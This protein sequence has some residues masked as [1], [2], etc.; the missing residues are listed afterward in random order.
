MVAVTLLTIIGTAALMVFNGSQ[1][2][3]TL[4]LARIDLQNNLRQFSQRFSMELQESGTDENGNLQVTISNNSGVNN[5]DVIRFAIP[6]CPCGLLPIDSNGEVNSWGAPTVWG[7]AG[8]GSNYTVQNNGKVA[9]CHLP[10]GNPNNTQNLSVNE[11]AVKAHLAH[12]DWLGA[13]NACSPSA[14]SNRQIQYALDADGIVWRR[15][16]NSAGTVQ[17]E[18][19]AAQE[20]DDFQ[21]SFDAT[22]E[23]VLV[24]MDLSK[25]GTQQRVINV[26]GSW[27]VLLRNK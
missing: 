19:M 2:M 27:N 25:I 17:S 26:S 5:S 7:Q 18:V 9:V 16:L 24:Q 15:V 12:G 13:C 21:V 23:K 11:N 20:V 22:Q 3:S 8:C 14:Y 10:P 1:Q 6:I 4:V